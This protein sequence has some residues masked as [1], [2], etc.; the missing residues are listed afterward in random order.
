MAARE[1]PTAASAIEAD[2]LPIF[3]DAGTVI[4]RLLRRQLDEGAAHAA[5]SPEEQQEIAAFAADLQQK[6]LLFQDRVSRILASTDD[7]RVV[8]ALLDDAYAAVTSLA[9]WADEGSSHLLPAIDRIGS[10]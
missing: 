8:V 10:S 7:P 2:Q 3:R 6:A 9:V 5:F 1:Q 4:E